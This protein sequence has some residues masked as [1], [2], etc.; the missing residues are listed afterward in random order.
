MSE[1]PVSSPS[2]Q[3][4]PHPEGAVRAVKTRRVGTFTCGVSLVLTG[5]AIALYLLWPKFDPVFFF[6]FCPLILVLLGGEI[7]AA[8]F[9]RSE[10]RIKYDLVS[11]VL[12]LVIGITAM[13]LSLIPI[14]VRWFGP[15]RQSVQLRMSAQSDQEI[16][17]LLKNDAAVIDCH[18]SAFL[19]SPA[20]LPSG[21]VLPEPDQ[22]QF[23]LTLRGPYTDATAFAADCARI[24]DEILQGGLS[25]NALTFF[26]SSGE[27]YYSLVLDST[28]SLHADV[29][30]LAARVETN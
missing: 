25:P 5:L 19:Y 11:M 7:L 22:L 6:R 9:S 14:A 3:P 26:C 17:Q 24:R 29:Q 15:E 2:P 13:V 12:C 28:F 30:Q 21:D 8:S 4:V 27:S 1:R 23:D 18:S 16:Y 10:L 20:A